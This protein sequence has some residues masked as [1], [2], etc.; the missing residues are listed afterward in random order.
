MAD[1]AGIYVPPGIGADGTAA[2]VQTGTVANSASSSEIVI[3]KR[4]RIDI[5]VN[6]AAFVA[7]GNSGMAAASAADIPLFANTHNFFNLGDQYDRVR[8]FNNS[9]ATITYWVTPFST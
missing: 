8:I 2:G 7:F 5:A 3:N 9:G 4:A 6:G 1:F